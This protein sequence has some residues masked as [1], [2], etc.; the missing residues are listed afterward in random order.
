M[1]LRGA[2][3]VA[4][5]ESAK[6]GAQPA[7]QILLGVCMLGPFAFLEVVRLQASLP[8]DTLYGRALRDSGFATPLVVLGFAGLWGLPV[9][10]SVIGGDLFAGEDRHRTWTTILTRSRSRA[11]LFTGKVLAA[12]GFSLLAITA[13]AAGSLAAGL[14]LVGHQPLVDLSGVVLLPARALGGVAIAWASALPPAFGF[15]AVAILVSAATRSGAAGVGVP[16]VAA[17]L[18]QLLA[19]A[20]GAD[21]FRRLQ[22]TSAFGAWHGL[23]QEHRYYRPLIDGAAVSVTCVVVCLAL[24]YR[25]LQRRDIAG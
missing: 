14:L 24:A 2:L 7:V 20:D 16:V 4:G 12:L 9:V 11:E 23:L 8:E 1:S 25:A 6:L 17:L 21:T 5:V 18:M 22:M 19:L 3:A 15:L 13:L 10:T